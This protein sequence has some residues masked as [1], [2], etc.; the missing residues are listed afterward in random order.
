MSM[1]TS[2]NGNIFRVTGLFAGNSLVNSPHKGQW[3]GALIFSLICTWTNSWAN[4]RDAGDLRRHRAHYDVIVMQ[5]AGECRNFKL[6]YFKL[7]KNWKWTILSVLVTFMWFIDPYSSIFHHWHVGNHM[8]V[9]MCCDDV[10]MAAMASQITRF[11]I[12][13]KAP[14]YWPLCG[15][16]T[17]DRWI[18]RTKGQ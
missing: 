9:S 11:M 15:E 3:R 2:S 1:M 13:C 18:P 10:I 14:R 5:W 12:V 6:L 7:F 8:L 17:G 4:N 16:F